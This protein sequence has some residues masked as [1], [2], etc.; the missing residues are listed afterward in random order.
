[1]KDVPWLAKGQLGSELC[2]PG[3]PMSMLWA[4]ETPDFTR[5]YTVI[6]GVGATCATQALHLNDFDEGPRNQQGKTH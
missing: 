3:F 1:M 4:L 5:S 6:H 2:T